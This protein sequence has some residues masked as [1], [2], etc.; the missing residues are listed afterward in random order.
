[1]SNLRCRSRPEVRG[2]VNDLGV[3]GQD[4]RSSPAFSFL[5]LK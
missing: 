3:S 2:E 5:V 1:M 4:F